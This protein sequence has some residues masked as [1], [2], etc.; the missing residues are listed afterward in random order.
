MKKE[1][2]DFTKGNP[3]KLILPF[4]VPLLLTSLLQQ[5]YNFVDALIV[6]Q[7]LGDNALAAVGNMGSVFFLIVGFSFGLANGF[8]VLIAQSFG[9]KDYNLLRRRIASTIKLACGLIIVLTTLSLIFLKNILIFLRTDDVILNDCLAYG[10]IIFAGLFTSISYNVCAAILRALGDSK[11]PLKAIVISSIINLS[12]DS[13]FI[14]VFHMGVWS[15]AIATVVAQIISTI[16]CFNRLKQISIIRLKREEFHNERNVYIELIKNGVP[17]AFMNSITAVGCMVVQYFVNGYGVNYTSAYAAC[18]KYLNLFMNPACTAGHAMSAFTSQN[19][20]AKKYDRIKE[21]LKVCLG[22]AFVSYFTLGMVMTFAPRFLADILLDG[23]KPINLAS[24]FL[25]IC[26][27]SI[28]AVDCLFVFRTGVQGMGEPMIPMWSGVVEMIL[29]IAIISLFMKEVGFK[30][31]A[32]AEV[33]AWVGALLM[34]MIAF[35]VILGKKIEKK[36][37]TS[38]DLT[39]ARKKEIEGYEGIVYRR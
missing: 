7:G 26:G 17:M 4:Y 15:A 19:Y 9:A 14:F 25:P 28:I 2:V 36:D 31:T 34:N 32:Y 37:E 22:I 1:V 3:I 8:G 23:S 5:I 20:G 33:G 6:G 11:T 12:L 38:I 35:A 21:G 27:V 16:V 13:L 10:Y 18:S 24:Q 29:R 30:A 39:V